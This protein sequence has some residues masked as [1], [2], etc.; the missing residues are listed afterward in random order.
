MYF[1]SLIC[2]PEDIYTKMNNNKNIIKEYHK[3]TYND[4]DG[5]VEFSP[6]YDPLKS[7]L[8]PFLISTHLFSKKLK[9]PNDTLIREYF[10]QLTSFLR[11]PI[12]KIEDKNIEILSSSYLFE[13][14]I[15]AEIF[16]DFH[17]MFLEAKNKENI[18]VAS[19]LFKKFYEKHGWNLE[20]S[21]DFPTEKPLLIDRSLIKRFPTGV[22]IFN[23]SSIVEFAKKFGYND[24]ELYF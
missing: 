15:Y 5:F 11:Q 1:K 20:I 14:P 7:D 17:Y 22:Y 8:G 12:T 23:P 18:D 16:P 24:K 2:T 19:E 6:N 9:I 4:F 10:V 21:D 3:F 13:I